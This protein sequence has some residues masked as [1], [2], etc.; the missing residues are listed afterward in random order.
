MQALHEW[1]FVA[2]PRLA[3]FAAAHRIVRRSR[4]I[5]IGPTESLTHAYIVSIAAHFQGYCRDLHTEAVQSYSNGIPGRSMR[6]RVARLLTEGRKLDRGNATAANLNNDFLRVGTPLLDALER[7]ERRNRRRLVRLQ[8]LNVWRNAI[9]H[10]QFQL[11]PTDAKTVEG[12]QPHMVFA[13]R[14]L[15][16]CEGLAVGMAA[17]VE[18]DLSRVVAEEASA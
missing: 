8:Q 9:V 17:I 3:R 1:Q 13:Q 6:A 15:R 4:A 18:A 14:A 12:T 7:R 11:S 16:A 2:L 10:H 5:A